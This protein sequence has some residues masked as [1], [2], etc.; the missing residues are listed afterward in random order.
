ME[1]STWIGIA[2]STFTSL[3][4][5]PQ[6]IKLF[7]TKDAKDV[8]MVMLAVLLMGLVLWVTYGIVLQNLIIIIANAFAFV[9]NVLTLFATVYYKKK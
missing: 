6:L 8:S 9:I 3:S 2:A 4:L 7:K 5:V 1:I